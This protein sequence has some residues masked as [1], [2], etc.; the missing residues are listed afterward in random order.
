LDLDKGWPTSIFCGKSPFVNF[1]IGAFGAHLEGF[2]FHGGF[3]RWGAQTFFGWGGP[4]QW[5][6]KTKYGPPLGA[7]KTLWVLLHHL[8]PQTVVHEVH[9]I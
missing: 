2:C 1:G 4:L 6:G 7:Q 8:L 9:Q 5:G 3:N